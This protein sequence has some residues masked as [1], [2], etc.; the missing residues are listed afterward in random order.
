VII[1]T[2]KSGGER[3]GEFWGELRTKS[4]TKTK[5]VSKT[6]NDSSPQERRGCQYARIRHIN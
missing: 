4:T 1:A 5:K 3:Q 6:K 2:R